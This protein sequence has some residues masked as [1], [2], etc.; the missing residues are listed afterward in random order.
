MTDTDRENEFNVSS[1]LQA[2]STEAKAKAEIECLTAE[3]DASKMQAKETNVVIAGVANNHNHKKFAANKAVLSLDIPNSLFLLWNKIN[4]LECKLGIAETPLISLTTESL[5]SV[6]C[7]NAASTMLQE[8]IRIKRSRFLANY[9]KAGG[10]KQ[11]N[12]LAQFSNMI[13]LKGEVNPPTHR[14]SY[15]AI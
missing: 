1:D 3:L 13:L 2:A 8:R 7:L 11:K 4:K 5:S 10:L 15:I 9:R 14:Y 12:L 6:L